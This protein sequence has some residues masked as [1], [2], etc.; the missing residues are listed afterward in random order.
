MHCIWVGGEKFASALSFVQGF[1]PKRGAIVRRAI[2]GIERRVISVKAGRKAGVARRGTAATVRLQSTARHGFVN[3][4]AGEDGARD[5]SANKTIGMTEI[6]L[7]TG[8]LVP[9]Q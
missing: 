6:P 8:E 1:L 9:P 7:H 3:T 4:G 2:G 5:C